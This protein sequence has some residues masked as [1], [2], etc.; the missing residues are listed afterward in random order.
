MD[1]A[2]LTSLLAQLI[3]NWEDEVVEFKRGKD[4]F[5]A[6][7]LGKYLSALANEANL[8]GRD[9]AWIVFGVDNKTRRVVGTTYKE[10]SEHLQATK[11]QVLDGTSSITFRDIQITPPVSGLRRAAIATTGWFKQWPN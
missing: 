2:A 10:G 9:R 5:S 8:R 3:A 4:S 6:T 1:Q 7:D 11:K